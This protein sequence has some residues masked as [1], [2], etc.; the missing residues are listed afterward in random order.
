MNYYSIEVGKLL[1]VS[2][3]ERGYNGDNATR[4]P[5][6]QHSSANVQTQNG[7]TGV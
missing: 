7:V 5:P 4:N 3:A 1:G 6:Q 2:T